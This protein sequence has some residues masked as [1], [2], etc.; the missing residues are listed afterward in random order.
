M[1]V[2][3]KVAQLCL[4]L[5][6]PR[7]YTAHGI[8]Q[9]RILE[10]GAFPF[11]R[12]SFRPRNQTGV[13]CVAGGFFTNLD[14]RET[15]TEY[16]MLQ[17]T[18]ITRIISRSLNVPETESIHW[19]NNAILLLKTSFILMMWPCTQ[20]VTKYPF[21]IES[22]NQV[23]GYIEHSKH[24]YLRGCVPLVSQSLSSFLGIRIKVGMFS[25]FPISS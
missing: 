3:V 2:K 9:A 18:V 24:I 4:T 8:L 16:I 1:K 21:M 10:W 20:Y 17:F 22:E 15:I 13:S 19:G 7:D 23:R 11:S 14:I 5:C 25:N 6:N 12:G